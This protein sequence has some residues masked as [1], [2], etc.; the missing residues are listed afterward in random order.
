MSGRHRC[1]SSFREYDSYESEL[2]DRDSGDDEN[3][4]RK[5]LDYSD[6]VALV[7]PHRNVK[8]LFKG[9]KGEFHPVKSG[10]R[11]VIVDADRAIINIDGVWKKIRPVNITGVVVRSKD[12]HRYLEF[13]QKNFNVSALREL[14]DI[15]FPEEN[16]LSEIDPK[17][18]CLLKDYAFY[19]LSPEDKE[20]YVKVMSSKLTCDSCFG[21]FAPQV[22]KFIIPMAY[23]SNRKSMSD[24]DSGL[25]ICPICNMYALLNKTVLM[26]A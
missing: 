24:F 1:Y 3:E 25:L 10:D 26:G 12:V 15:Y 4:N 17:N 21:E 9:I 22:E 13:L 14:G 19:R 20:R 18:I 7:G 5:K 2:F 16:L 23:V 6:S 11:V 8:D